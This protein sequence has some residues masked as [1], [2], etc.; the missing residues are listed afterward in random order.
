MRKYFLEVTVERSEDRKLA[1]ILVNYSAKIKKGDTVIIRGDEL[2][3][4]LLLEVYRKVV[5]G[6]AGIR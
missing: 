1:D 3:K 6:E 4:P 2:G 5:G